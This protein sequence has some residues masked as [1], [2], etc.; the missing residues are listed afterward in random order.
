MDPTKLSFFINYFP[1][2]GP[3]FNKNVKVAFNRRSRTMSPD[4]EHLNR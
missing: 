2:Y 3:E 1:Q 4:R